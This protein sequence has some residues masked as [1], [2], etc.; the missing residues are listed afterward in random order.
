MRGR[1]PTPAAINRLRGN[2]GKRAQRED[3]PR[4]KGGIPE[5]PPHLIKD[6][7]A[8]WRRV[9]VLLMT[10]GLLAQVD[11][12]A[13]AAYCSAYARWIEAE[14]ILRG[15]GLL[16]KAWGGLPIPN[17]ALKIADRAMSQMKAFLVEFGMTPSSRQ[18]VQPINPNQGD[19]LDEKLFG[20]SEGITP[21]LLSHAER[22]LVQ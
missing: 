4:V 22:Q 17:P 10:A 9:S 7:R 14:T 6:A 21:E 19:L 13:L 18:R 16:V 8:E 1:K 3:I 12:A 5:C 20:E 15:S 11:R 2:P